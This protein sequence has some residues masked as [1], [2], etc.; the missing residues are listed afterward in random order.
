MIAQMLVGAWRFLDPSLTI[1]SRLRMCWCV[2]VPCGGARA[3]VRVSYS[4]MSMKTLREEFVLTTAPPNKG[5][6]AACRRPACM[7]ATNLKQRPSYKV[8]W[9]PGE[10]LLGL[11]LL[12][13]PHAPLRRAWHHT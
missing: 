3:I 9:R 5:C 10:M 12:A 13:P 8:R 4:Y 2:T 7:R 11:F 6:F 1:L